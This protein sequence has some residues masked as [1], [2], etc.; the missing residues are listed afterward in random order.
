MQETTLILYIIKL[1]LGGI[2]AFLAILLWSRTRDGAW[3]SLVAGAIISYA[4]LVYQ[5]LGDLGI[6]FKNDIHIHGLTLTQL[7]FTVV[8]SIFYIIAFI[9]MLIRTRNK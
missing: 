9:L 8:P 7:I 4:G 2:V 6:S 5:L 3:M 1:A